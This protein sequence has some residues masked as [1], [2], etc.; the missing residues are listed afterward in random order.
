MLPLP[1]PL[2]DIAEVK[3]TSF[4]YL[5]REGIDLHQGTAIH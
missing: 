1:L 5:P 2:T 3:A 4:L